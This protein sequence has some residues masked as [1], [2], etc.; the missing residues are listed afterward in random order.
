MNCYGHKPKITPTE[1]K[2]MELDELYPKTKDE[3][4]FEKKVYEWRRKLSEILIAP[5]NKT[6][7]SKL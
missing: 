5:F 4:T 2:L 6:S 1:E 3:I 7:W